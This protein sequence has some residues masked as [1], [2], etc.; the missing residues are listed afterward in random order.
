LIDSGDTAWM[1][2][3]SALVLLM[4]PGLAFFYGGLVRRKNI[5][6]VFMQCLAAVCVIGLQWVLFGYSLAFGPD[7][8]G[9]IGGLSYAAMH[10]VGLDPNPVYAATVPHLLFMVYQM[11]FAV[12]TPA[13]IIGAFAERMKFSAFL[14]FAV[15]WATLVSIPWRI[16]YGPREDGCGNS[17]RST[18]P[19]E[20]SCTSAPGWLPSPLPWS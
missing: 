17:A 11:M 15:L 4:T 8:G 19:A 7:H 5:L 14:V 6:S 3:S 9:V 13:L 18:S 10:G 20:P 2:I 12:I 16:G 1:M